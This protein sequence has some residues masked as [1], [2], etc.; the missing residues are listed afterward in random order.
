MGSEIGKSCGPI[1]EVTHFH[2]VQCTESNVPKSPL[3]MGIDVPPD[4]SITGFDAI[5]KMHVNVC[6]I[7]CMTKVKR[8]YKLWSCKEEEQ[9]SQPAPPTPS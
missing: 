1:L 3:K 7:F 2:P 9:Q 4:I 8:S 5:S 6:L